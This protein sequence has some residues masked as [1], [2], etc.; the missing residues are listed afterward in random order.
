MPCNLLESSVVLHLHLTVFQ[1]SAQQASPQ[2][3]QPPRRDCYTLICGLSC[4]NCGSQLCCSRVWHTPWPQEAPRSCRN[5][6]WS[7]HA[8]INDP[9]VPVLILSPAF[10]SLPSSIPFFSRLSPPE[11]WAFW[12]LSRATLKTR[13]KLSELKF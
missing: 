10:F 5:W 11:H 9:T 4:Q 13:E 2:P 7:L 6:T 8:L 1:I 3:C 12:V